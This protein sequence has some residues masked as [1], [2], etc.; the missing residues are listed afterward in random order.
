MNRK[1]LDQLSQAH[2]GA[3]AAVLVNLNWWYV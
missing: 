1:Q 3:D 2:H